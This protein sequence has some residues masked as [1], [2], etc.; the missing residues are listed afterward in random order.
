L[1]TVGSI[2]VA[3]VYAGDETH[4]EPQRVPASVVLES[5]AIA[6][7]G[8]KAFGDPLD[9]TLD[10]VIGDAVL[11]APQ[12]VRFPQ[13]AGIEGIGSAGIDDEFVGHKPFSGSTR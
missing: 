12:A 5:D 1:V 7:A 8:A 4:A 10:R 2:V 3:V 13:L 9:L 6:P 11:G